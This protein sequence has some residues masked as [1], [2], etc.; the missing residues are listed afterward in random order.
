MDDVLGGQRHGGVGVPAAHDH[1]AVAGQMDDA[2]GR[3]DGLVDDL[4]G[5]RSVEAP[6]ILVHRAVLVGARTNL[7]VQGVAAQHAVREL[8]GLRGA[9]RTGHRAHEDIAELR[10]EVATAGRDVVAVL[11]CLLVQ[12]TCNPLTAIGGIDVDGASAIGVQS[13]N[14]DRTPVGVEVVVGG[15]MPAAVGLPVLLD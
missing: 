7:A 3:G 4:L 12:A 8:V 1:P 6:Q 10:L 15:A 2:L 14:P 5:G 11:A 9:T 13:R